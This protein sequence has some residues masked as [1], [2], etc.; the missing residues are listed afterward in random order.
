L[1]YNRL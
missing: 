1:V